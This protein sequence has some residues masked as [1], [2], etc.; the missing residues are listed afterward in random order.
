MLSTLVAGYP[1]LLRQA[2]PK[3]DA[4]TV[5]RKRFELDLLSLTRAAYPI[6]VARARELVDVQFGSSGSAT[7]VPDESPGRLIL[8]IRR[9]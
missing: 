4:L 9:G 8:M 3:S 7:D 2:L 6:V 1:L 5:A